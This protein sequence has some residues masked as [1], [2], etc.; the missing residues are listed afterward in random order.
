MKEKIE[1][2]LRKGSIE[3]K[4]LVT[5]IGFSVVILVLMYFFVT[6]RNEGIQFASKE[7]AGTEVLKPL[8][9]LMI[10]SSKAGSEFACMDQAVVAKALSDLKAQKDNCQTL[11]IDSKISSLESSV[12][13]CGSGSDAVKAADLQ[14]ATRDVIS[15]V[16]DNSNLTLDPDLDSYYLMDACCVRS[17]DMAILQAKLLQD[18]QYCCTNGGPEAFTR[19]TVTCARIED[20]CGVM[21]SDLQTSMTKNASGDVKKNLE[22]SIAP[23]LSSFRS[24]AD[25]EHI[26]N[27]KGDS[28]RAIVRGLQSEL[29]AAYTRN[30]SLAQASLDQLHALLDSRAT[31]FSHDRIRSVLLALFL[32]ILP[33]VLSRRIASYIVQRVRELGD[34]LNQVQEGYLDTRVTVVSND[35]LGKLG[36]G[37]NAMVD[38]IQESQVANEQE[39]QKAQAFAEEAQAL[40]IESEKYTEYLRQS[41]SMVLVAMEERSAG[42]LNVQVSEEGD[43]VVAELCRGFNDSVVKLRDVIEG[44]Q[45][46]VEATASASSQI[47]SSTEEMAAGQHE[48]TMQT[49]DVASAVEEMTKTIIENS[50]NARDTAQSA[51]MARETADHGVQSIIEAVEG[52]KRIANVVHDS[53][54]T[55]KVLGESSSQIGEIITV[56]NDIADQTNL[57]ALNAAIEA[58]RAGEQGR[59]FA[60]VADEVRK[61]AERTTKATKEISTMISRIQTETENAISSMEAGTSEVDKGIHLTDQ[62]RTAFA[63]ISDAVQNVTTMITQIAVAS[64]QQSSASETISRSIQAISEVTTQTASGTDQIAHAAD[65]LNRL[66]EN[67]HNLVSHFRLHDEGTNAGHRPV[68]APDKGMATAQSK[69]SH[70]QYA[71]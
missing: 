66:T 27:S 31:G 17:Q 4:L 9:A 67:L 39:R 22:A 56:I 41:V 5:T 57:L 45:N 28:A 15:T 6:V 23:A 44:V 59:G 3:Q 26:G 71:A 37:F 65:D 20:V 48:L 38:K 8:T 11:E 21:E 2:Y 54:Q 1:M 29:D 58:A 55:V 25:L 32:L 14:R 35:D 60:V 68:I 43:A 47:S 33:V 7:Q 52:M 70:T 12:Q 61:L 10:E 34:A 51:E 64:E 42:N 49:N 62:A 16:A 63:S 69:H 30:A 24:L 19:L 53:A 40:K 36:V 18:L 46:A 13:A 50:N